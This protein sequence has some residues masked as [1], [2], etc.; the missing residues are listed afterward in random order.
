M[1]SLFIFLL[2]AE[3]LLCQENLINDN[4]YKNINGELFINNII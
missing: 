1:S 3:Y 4:A 2:I